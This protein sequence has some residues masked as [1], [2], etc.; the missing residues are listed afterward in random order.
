MQFSRARDRKNGEIEDYFERPSIIHILGTVAIANFYKS[1]VNNA[2]SD[3]QD[4]YS[5]DPRDARSLNNSDRTRLLHDGR[6][7][8]RRLHLL[9]LVLGLRLV[10]ALGGQVRLDGAPRPHPKRLR[11]RPADRGGILLLRL[12]GQGG[13]HGEGVRGQGVRQGPHREGEE[14]GLRAVGEEDPR[15]AGGRVERQG[16]LL[17]QDTL[18]VS[19]KGMK[20]IFLFFT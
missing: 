6:A 10:V 15:Q 9:L 8:H 16:A 11:V 13:G 7:R 17:R 1:Q 20:L 2:I 14:A 5:I 3:C 12:P 19:G 18:N 4:I